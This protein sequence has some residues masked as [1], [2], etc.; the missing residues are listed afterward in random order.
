[1]AELERESARLDLHNA[2]VQLQVE[3][4]SKVAGA[5]STTNLGSV[6]RAMGERL[7]EL[8]KALTHAQRLVKEHAEKE[9]KDDR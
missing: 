6:A 1:M 2:E 5:I 4:L 8:D 9:A 7:L 3:K